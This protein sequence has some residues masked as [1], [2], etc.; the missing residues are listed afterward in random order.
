MFTLGFN[1][2]KILLTYDFP[3]PGS[4]HEKTIPHTVL[5]MVSSSPQNAGKASETLFSR[6]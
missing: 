3:D 6:E 1:D 5:I 4:L 2:S